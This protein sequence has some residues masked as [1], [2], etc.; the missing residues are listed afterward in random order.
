MP[1]FRNWIVPKKQGWMEAP[2]LSF[3]WLGIFV[4]NVMLVISRT[5]KFNAVRVLISG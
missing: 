4:F 3:L 1:V 5:S 2:A